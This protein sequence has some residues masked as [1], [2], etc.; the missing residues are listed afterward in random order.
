[1]KKPLTG[2]YFGGA[3]A[4]WVRGRQHP[5]DVMATTAPEDNYLDAALNAALQVRGLGL[6]V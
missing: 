3:R 1:M 4:V 6:W 5:V 2:R